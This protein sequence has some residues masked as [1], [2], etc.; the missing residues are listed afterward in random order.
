MLLSGHASI[1]VAQ[2]VL[3]LWPEGP[4]TSNLLTGPETGDRCISNVTEPTL[5]VYH[6]EP[7]RAAGAA[8]LVIPGGGYAAV[9]LNHEGAD[10]AGWLSKAGFVAGVLKYR[11]PNGRFE[12]PFQDAQ[13]A[14]RIMRSRA[15]EW[16]ADTHR[17]GVLGFSAGGHL[18]STVG[19]HFDTDFSA[20]K[21]DRLDVS[22]RPDFVVLVYPVITLAEDYAHGGSRRNL[23]GENAA[24]A[25]IARFSNH[26]RVTPET[27][28]AFLV[29]SSDDDVVHP[30]NSVVFYRAL[31]EN[32]VPAELHLFDRGGHGYSLS[33]ESPA[34]AWRALAEEWLH[35]LLDRAA[36]R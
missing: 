10:V 32:G 33:E 25:E 5:T 11:L 35:R 3:P 21:G 2:D 4:P 34:S 17:I 22:H 12:V 13:Q 16:G 7:D 8:V 30:F 31:E 18:A 24:S 15:E 6:P 27:P 20:G 19:T 14:L 23:L 29:H 36:S 28:P 9:C 1:A 26:L